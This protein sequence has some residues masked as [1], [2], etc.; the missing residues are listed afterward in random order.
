MTM[1]TAAHYLTQ[2]SA[3]SM[4]SSRSQQISIQYILLFTCRSSKLLLSLRF[5]NPIPLCILFST[6]ATCP[7]LLILFRLVTLLLFGEQYQSL[8]TSLQFSPHPCYFDPLGH[9]HHGQQNILDHAQHKTLTV[10]CLSLRDVTLLQA[11][12]KLLP[13]PPYLPSLLPLL[14][15]VNL[16]LTLL[17]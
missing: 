7:A 13:L 3:W 9:G 12:Y 6:H 5:P 4:H 15:A 11:K 2:S 8:L 10:S 16:A 1:S 17:S 14:L